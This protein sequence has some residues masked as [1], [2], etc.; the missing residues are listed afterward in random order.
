MPFYRTLRFRFLALFSLFIALLFGV[1]GWL[2]I[3]AMVGLATHM[4]TEK[5]LLLAR[6]VSST[7][8]PEQ[9]LRVV[10]G[11]DPTDPYYESTRGSLSELQG[12][13]DHVVGATEENGKSIKAVSDMM[14]QFTV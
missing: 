1:S 8:D 14:S 5:G 9:Y 10:S 13:A 4:F 11:L 6:A 2:S 3:N 12:I 7:I